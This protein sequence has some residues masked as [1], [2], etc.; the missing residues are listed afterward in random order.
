MQISG[1]KL[2]MLLLVLKI[3]KG[4]SFNNNLFLQILTWPH[5]ESTI[6]QHDLFF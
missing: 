5:T 6:K 1:E 3:V 4:N 2:T